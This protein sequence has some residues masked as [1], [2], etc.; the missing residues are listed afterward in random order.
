MG[1]RERIGFTWLS[2]EYA[3]E[4][5]IAVSERKQTPGRGYGEDKG[6]ERNNFM[7]VKI[8]TTSQSYRYQRVEGKEGKVKDRAD[9]TRILTST[10]YKRVASR[11]LIFLSFHPW[12]C[13]SRGWR[14][15]DGGETGAC[16][17]RFQVQ[18]RSLS[19]LFANKTKPRP[20]TSQHEHKYGTVSH[21]TFASYQCH[22]RNPL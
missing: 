15:E 13:P 1:N 16:R 3:G 2:Y 17:W 7:D 18:S 5:D 4:R 14:I 8:H 20:C 12:A 21:C 9:D 10:S 19:L 11:L 22:L 6:V